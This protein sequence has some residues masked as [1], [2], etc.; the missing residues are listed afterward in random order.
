MIKKGSLI[1]PNQQCLIGFDAEWTKNYKIK[2]GNVPFCFSLVSLVQ[3]EVNYSCLDAG[4]LKFRYVQLYCESHEE[5]RELVLQF[6]SYAEQV[7]DSLNSCI[8]CGH[9]M[10]SDLS[11][12]TNYARFLG[13]TELSSIEKLKNYWHGRKYSGNS[14]VFD[15]RYDIRQT[16]LGH[17]RRLVDMSND[18]LLDVTQP[19]LGHVSMTKLHNDYVANKKDDIRERISVMNIR[20]SLCATI[21]YWLNSQVLQ[22]NSLRPININKTIGVNLSG[23]FGWID[24]NTFRGL[25]S[26][27]EQI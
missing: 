22:G 6:N 3:D 16:F 20:H 17:S 15:T 14:C 7:I 5:S 10:S 24:S 2:N 4:T 1:F 11:V 27:N 26:K 19:E 13:V 9:Q 21:L 12:L 25:L 23:E 18:F 8:L